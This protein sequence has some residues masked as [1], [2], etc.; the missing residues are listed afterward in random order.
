MSVYKVDTQETRT[1]NNY[2]RTSYEMLNRKHRRPGY[3]IAALPSIGPF[4]YNNS[5][6][7]M[8]FFDFF[9]YHD[10]AVSRRILSEFE[11]CFCFNNYGID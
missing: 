1:Y 4:I 2:R 6:Y 11:L 8:I 5:I 7:R 9:F 10:Q 3:T